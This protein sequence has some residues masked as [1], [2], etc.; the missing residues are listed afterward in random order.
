MLFVVIARYR[1][2]SGASPFSWRKEAKA[3]IVRDGSQRS[4]A[5]Q[6]ETRA[7]GVAVDVSNFFWS[8]DTRVLSVC[9]NC[10]DRAGTSH[11]IR[12]ALA[13]PPPNHTACNCGHPPSYSSVVYSHWHT[14]DG[15]RRQDSIPEACLVTGRWLVWTT[16]QLE[17][18]HGCL[19]SDHSRRYRYAVEAE[20]RKRGQISY[21]RAR[22]LLSEQ[23]VS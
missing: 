18:K 11:V 22:S 17:D 14:H 9:T 5:P 16:T 6:V 12:R 13:A 19:R 4:R 15:W 8:C 10:P 21:A 7:V 20:R 2:I 23:K 1:S 3:E